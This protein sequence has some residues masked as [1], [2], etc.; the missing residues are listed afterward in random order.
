MKPY[1]QLTFK[2][3][4]KRLNQLAQIALTHYPIKPVKVSIFSY[5]TNLIYRVQTEDGQNLVLRLA[6]PGWRSLQDLQSGVMWMAA[7]ARDTDIPV[8]Q[9][10]PSK[11][12]AFV[13]TAVSPHVSQ[14]WHAIL[15]SWLPGKL[16]GTQ[17]NEANLFKMGTLFSQ[18][19]QHGQQWQP[20]ANF[21]KRQFTNYISRGETNHLFS[22]AFQESLTAKQFSAL[23]QVRTLVESAYQSLDL[24]D[25]RIIHCDLWH[26]NIK[27]QKG[28][29]LAPFDFEDTVWGFRLHDIAMAMLD[30]AEDVPSTRYESLLSAF[31]DG[32]AQNSHW[33]QGNLLLL[34]LGRILW[35]LNFMA[36]HQ[37]NSVSSSVPF[38]IEL[39]ERCLK[40]GKLVG[41]LK[42]ET[43][44]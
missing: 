30:L 25:L 32:Y 20:P 13:I 15:Q 8:A 4:L 12:G 42:P 31:R 29:V 39:F 44:L 43:N 22:D 37:P 6:R 23:S 21:T 33:P 19:H 38:Y 36:T 18:L 41:P 17:L 34:Q 11:Q 14:P 7:L 9:V 5:S 28:G 1:D 35:Q 27:I 26:D 3:K 16:L 40:K 2:G 10:I 24:A